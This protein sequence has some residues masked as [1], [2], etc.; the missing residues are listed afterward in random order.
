MADFINTVDVI[1]DDVLTDSII[2]KTVTEYKDDQ[3]KQLGW[4]AFYN[5]IALE[6]VDLP[7]ITIMG[8]GVFTGCSGL[9]KI[10]IPKITALQQGTFSGCSSLVVLDLPGV[11]ALMGN[12]MVKNCYALTAMILRYTSVCG[13]Q[14]S[15]GLA[16]SSIATGKAYI[17]VPSALVDSYKAATNWSQFADQFRALEDYT[18]DG[19]ITGELDETK[20]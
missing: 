10:N 3:I 18:V 16:A 8:Q 20:I 6:C 12:Q 5:C 14:Y 13:F 4:Y 2:M 7:N 11:T 9:K 17:Y 15:G 1:G 19:T